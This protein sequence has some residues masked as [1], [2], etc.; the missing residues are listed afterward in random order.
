MIYIR[1]RESTFRVTLTSRGGN[2][3]VCSQMVPDVSSDLNPQTS[4]R[5]QEGDT[6][7]H[8]TICE[9]QCCPGDRLTEGTP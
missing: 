3:F 2:V 4:V 6:L 1:V 8:P 5:T 7:K 9:Y